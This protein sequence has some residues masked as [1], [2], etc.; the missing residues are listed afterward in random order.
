MV[1]KVVAK[2]SVVVRLAFS[3]SG[4]L[5]N[6]IGSVCCPLLYSSCILSPGELS[7]HL[8]LV[9]YLPA[10]LPIGVVA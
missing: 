4:V 2:Q 9:I 3:H 6:L 8:C 5:V 10:C 7:C 1:V